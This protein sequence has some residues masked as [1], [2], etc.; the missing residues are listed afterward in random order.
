MHD[1]ELKELIETTEVAV[2]AQELKKVREAGEE[3]T[4][5]R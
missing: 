4:G 3:A 2:L 5:E 1:Q